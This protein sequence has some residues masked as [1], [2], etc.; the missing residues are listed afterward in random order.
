M[1]T[2]IHR[3]DIMLSGADAE[4]IPDEMETQVAQRRQ[5]GSYDTV[6]KLNDEIT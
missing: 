1:K 2:A 3:D 4:E 6:T 5:S